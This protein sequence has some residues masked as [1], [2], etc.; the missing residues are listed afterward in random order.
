MKRPP[1]NATAGVWLRKVASGRRGLRSYTYRKRHWF[2]GAVLELDGHEN[3]FLVAAVL[4]VVHL[5]LALAVALV[6]CLTRL[7][8]VFNGGAVV[9][10]LE[11]ATARNRGP[12]IV[13]HVAVEANALAGREPDDPYTRPLVLGQQGGTDARVRILA[14]ALELGSDVGRPRR[15]VLLLRGL[16]DHAQSHGNSSKNAGCHI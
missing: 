16:V 8:G 15:F 11:G 5:E 2:V 9:H 7:V 13:E 14:L 10:V 1:W 6:A 12:E 4:Q 3:H